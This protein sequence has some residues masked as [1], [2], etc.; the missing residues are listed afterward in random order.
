M[1]FKILNVLF[2]MVFMSIKRK[3]VGQTTMEAGTDRARPK[4]LKTQ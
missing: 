4:D 2:I 3:E 1:A